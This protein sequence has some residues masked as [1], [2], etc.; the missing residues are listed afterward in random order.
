MKEVCPSHASRLFEG[1]PGLLSRR[2]AG[3]AALVVALAMSGCASRPDAQRA[4]QGAGSGASLRDDDADSGSGRI[5]GVQSGNSLGSQ[6]GQDLATRHALFKVSAF[7]AL[8]GWQQD[9]VNEAWVAFRE[10]CRAL[11]KKPSWKPL[12]AEVRRIKDPKAGRAFIEREFALLTVQNTDR[13]REGEITGYYEPLLLGRTQR[14]ARFNVPVYGVPNDLYILDWK[15]IPAAQRKGIAYV[16]PSGRQLVAAQAGQPGALR[17]ELRRFTLDTLDRRLRVRIQGDE[18]WPYYNRSEIAQRTSM[19]APVLA[20]VDD[21]VALY[22]MQVQGAGRIRM[23]DGSVLRLQFADQNGHP[24]K[25]MQLAAQGNER[26][27]TRGS[28]TWW[29][30]ERRGRSRR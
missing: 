27:Q 10:S 5:T 18:A 4:E 21:A 14:D 26:V 22:A 2:C 16:K 28:V 13:T 19:D 11:E 20:W 1:P 29:R 24:F 17:I 6:P 9:N 15:N 8:P 23:P 12:C 7:D 3:A 25:P 30:C